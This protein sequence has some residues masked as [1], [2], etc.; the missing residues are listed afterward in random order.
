MS[1]RYLFTL[2]CIAIQ[3]I[4]FAQTAS[5]K[6]V[7]SKSSDSSYHAVSDDGDISENK[8]FFGK[9]NIGQASIVSSIQW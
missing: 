3:S 1:R 9:Q 8:S 4:F 6:S 2:I 5:E 7:N